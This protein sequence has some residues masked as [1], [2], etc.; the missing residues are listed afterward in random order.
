MQP[1]ERFLRSR[2]YKLFLR[3]ERRPLNSYEKLA[4]TATKLVRWTPD[5]R[6]AKELEALIQFTGLRVT[7]TSVQSL[8]PFSIICFALLGII[9]AVTGLAGLLFAGVIAILGIPVGYYLTT[10]PRGYAKTVRIRASSQLV[11]AVL[12]LVVSMRIS[13]NL[14]RALRFAAANISGALAWDLRKLL[15]DIEMRKYYS[16]TEALDAYIAKWKQENEE[17]AEALR[18]IRDSESQTPEKGKVILDEALTIILEGTKTRMKHYA[19]D[20][21]LPVMIIHMMGIMLPVLGSIMAPL[22]AIFMSDLVSPIHFIIGYDVVLPILLI[23]FIHIALQKR[24]MTFSPVDISHHPNLPKEGRF[25]L[26]GHSVPV[27]P[28]AALILFAFAVPALLYFAQHP[29]YLLQGLVASGSPR[30]FDPLSLF[31]SLLLTGGIAASLATAFLLGNSQ[32]LRVQ[33]SIQ[34]IEGEFELALFQF[35]N[36]VSGG[37]PTEVAIEKS[38][39]DMK[40]LQIANFFRRILRNI[41]S[42]G[43]TFE[44]AV[45]HPEW[46]AIRFYPSKLVRN[47]MSTVVDTSRKGVSY[48]ADSMLRIAAYLK[49]IRETQEYIRDLLEETT[50]SMK[51]QA[52]FLT[53]IITGLIVSISDII[54]QILTRLGQYLSNLGLSD[55]AGFGDLSQIFGNAEASVSPELF[56]LIIGVYLI[57]VIAILGMFLTKINE[58][59]NKYAQAVLTGRMLLVGVAM[60]FL[61]ALISSLLF[62][63]FIRSALGSLGVT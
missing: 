3:H 11:L 2:E 39:A 5:K 47:I 31:M 55:S 53:P 4:R 34:K 43:M 15:W 19:Q 6:K 17:F 16:A 63:D 56:Q 41:R 7:P 57:E 44:Q 48:A 12:Y 26:G 40:D 20:L 35:G 22:V 9:L 29:S 54:T 24:P 28:F 32:R 14:E 23:V 21:R 36:R 38:I 33:R 8:L 58:G 25:T 1:S 30:T 27:L 50:S 10:Y 59:D 51:F 13:P 18:L 52:Y 42:L 45:F 37:T 60:Y 49:N 61:V 46:G 62:G